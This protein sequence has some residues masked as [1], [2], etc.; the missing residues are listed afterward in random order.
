MKITKKL[1]LGFGACA[2]AMGFVGAM[3]FFMNTTIT[4]SS[5]RVIEGNTKLVEH[6]QRM[7]ANINMMR[8]YEKDLFLNIGDAAA[9]TKYEKSWHEAKEHAQQRMAQLAKLSIDPK[10]QDALAAINGQLDA[11]AKGFTGVVARVRAGALRTPAEANRALEEFKDA[12]RQAE[13][14]I[15]TYAAKQDLDVARAIQDMEDST[16]R[17]QVLMSAFLLLTFMGVGA[18]ATVLIRSIRRPL[19]DIEALV[20]DMGQGEGDLSRRLSYTGT[21]ELGAICDGVN[22]FVEKLRQTI[23]QVAQTAEQ[24]ASATHELS[25]TA[26]QINQTTNELSQSSERQRV[27]MTQSSSALE[28]M[29]ASIHQVRGAASDAEGVADGSLAMTAQGTA[30][31]DESNQAMAAIKESSGKVNRITGVIADIA[32]QTNLLSLNAAIEA[33]KAGTHGKGFAVVADE[34][35]KLA[36]RS[37]SAARE[38]S[39]LIQESGERVDM[40]VGS[41]D[42]VGRSLA[43]IEAATRENTDRIRGISR[44]ME[45]QSDASKEMVAAVG[46]TAQITEQNASATTQLA[47][48]IQEV[49]RTIDELARI[50][51][52]LKGQTAKFK[53]A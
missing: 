27:A 7:R 9:V 2:L 33:A 23:S 14:A 40:G 3:G 30:A 29:S 19:E 38:I 28:Q 34:I 43:S 51:N 22:Q 8:R 37:G 52:E 44:A 50:A 41:V 16:R 36:E 15:T 49:A 53:L 45:E 11:Y 42:S 39:G 1:V 12:T 46:T 32:R 4:S 18:F 24:V 17:G 31:A 6:A 48:T 10:D 47:S 35:R 20:F 13:A 21:D 26:E 5:R 25:A